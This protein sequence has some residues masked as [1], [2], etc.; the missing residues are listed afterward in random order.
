MLNVFLIQAS[1]LVGFF[2][3]AHCHAIRLV[4]F[5]LWSGLRLHARR[6]FDVRG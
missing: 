2:S 1:S 6:A 5:V 4:D 3:L